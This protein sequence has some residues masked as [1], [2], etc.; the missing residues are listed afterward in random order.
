MAITFYRELTGSEFLE[1]LENGM[2]PVLGFMTMDTIPK[3]KTHTIC[4]ERLLPKTSRKPRY[5]RSKVDDKLKKSTVERLLPCIV[6]GQ[7][8]PRDIVESATRR[9]CNRV[10]IEG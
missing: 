2:I 4:R 5:E 10:G 3:Q 7:K 1:R 9:A 6:D 8:I